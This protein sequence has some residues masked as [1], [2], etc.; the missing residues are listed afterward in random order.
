MAYAPIAKLENFTGKKDNTQA[1][2]ND[3]SKAIIANNWDNA[4]DLQ[5][6]SYFLK[7]TAD[8]CNNNSINCLA[9]TFT[10]IKQNN[11]ETVTTYLECFHRIL[12]Q[13]QAIDTVYFTEPQ[14]LNQFIRGLYSSILQYVHPL[15]PA[16][17][18]AAVTHA[19]DFKSA[20][21]KANHAQAVN[22]VM[23]GS[24]DLNSTL[25]QISNTINQ[26]IEEYLADNSTI[27]QP[28]Q[29]HN[30][31]RNANCF[32]NQSHLTSSSNQQWQPEMYVCHNCAKSKH[33]PANNAAADLLSTSISD[34]SL[35]TAATSNISTAATTMVVYQLIPSSSNLPSGSHSQNLGTNATQ[36]LNFQNYLS[37]LVIP[38]DATPSNPETNPIQKLTSNILP[39][40]VTKNKTLAAIFLFDPIISGAALEKKPITAMYTNAKVDGHF[41]K[42]ILDSIDHAASAHIIIANGATKTPIGKID[43]F[44]FEINGIIIPIKVLA[45]MNNDWLLKTHVTFDW[46]TQK[47]QLIFGGQHTQTPATC[48]H[49]KPSN[50][51]PLI[52]FKEKTRKPIWEAYQVSWTDQ[53]HNKLPL[54]PSWNSNVKGKQKETELIWTFDQAWET[55]NDYNKL[56]DWEWEK[57]DNGKGKGK[58]TILEETTSTSEITNGWTSSYLIAPDKDHWT[59]THYYCKPCHKE[60]YDYP[61]KQSKWDNELCFTCGKQLLDKEMWNDIP[62]RGGTCDTLC[63]YTIFISDWVSHGTPITAA[64][65]RALNCLDSY[66]HDEE[67]IWR[68]ANTKVEGA[69]PSEILEI[70]NN[71]PELVNIIHISNSDA[72]ID[73]ETGPENFHEY[74][75]NLAPTR[76]EQKHSWASKSE[77]PFN[78]DSN[79]DNDD[80]ENTSSTLEIPATTMVQLASKSSLVKRG[81]NIR[82]GIIDAGYIRNIIA[83]LQNDS[84]KTYIIEPNEKIAQTI[85]LSLVKMVQLVSVGNREELRIT[86]KGIQRFGLMDR[87]DIPVNMAEEEIVDQGEIIS[88]NQAISILPYGQYMVEIKWKVKK[89]NQIFETEPTLCK[90]EKIRL[91]N[92]H[93]PAKDYSHIKIPIYNNTGNIILCEYVNITSQTIYEQSECYLFQ[94]EQLEQMNMRN[95]DSLQCMQLKMLLNNFN[96][97]FASENKFG[98][99]DIIQHQIKTEDTMPIKQ[100]TYK[101]NSIINEPMV[102]T[103]GTHPEKEW[104]NPI[105]CEL[106]ETQ[107]CNSKN[108]MMAA[109]PDGKWHSYDILILYTIKKKKTTE[110]LMQ[111]TFTKKQLWKKPEKD[112][113]GHQYIQTSSNMFKIMMLINEEKEQDPV[114]H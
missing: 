20:E 109:N 44:L 100:R 113:I 94:S 32:Q 21:L 103:S 101:A 36:N 93:I 81:I 62:G 50:A 72:F 84:E 88:T 29:W 112:T 78:P 95:L 10:T 47:L 41:I 52:E 108:L 92:L 56:A 110:M 99:T 80:D 16:N 71:F 91:I 43:D 59:Q 48:G 76:E 45:L 27:Y 54:V 58:K 25:K 14:I 28:P 9:N 22:L 65:H 1:W 89:Q 114:N 12:Y 33:L 104:K 30:N 24:S 74:Y 64:W 35:L 90:S 68:M 38:E 83:M 26:K 34:P 87:I 8:S 40:T 77:L 111:D 23:N 57:E 11:T 73:K 69:T 19:R 3:V 49:F 60:C 66:T 39:A 42:L 17:F 6:I 63:Q 7:E 82:K 85:F 70:K 31:Q 15:H 75:Q 51:Q 46:T 13:I 79:S 102:I 106:Q 86:A 4:R 55:K 96:N 98:R 97:I 105:L 107:W 61:K 37:L 67:E 2:I 53:D 5:A 18:Q